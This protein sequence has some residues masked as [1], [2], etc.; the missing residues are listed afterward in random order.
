M[1]NTDDLFSILRDAAKVEGK[2]PPV[3]NWHPKNCG[4][5]DLTIKANGEWWHEGTPIG[6][7]KLYRLFSTVLRKDDNHYFLVT[8]VEKI[9]IEV[10]WQPFVIVD[11]D[12]IKKENVPVYIFTDSCENR[13][14]LTSKEQLKFSNFEEQELPIIKV[15]RN[16]YAS[17]SRSCYYRLVEEA[18]LKENTDKTQISIRS[19]N[20]DFIL[21]EFV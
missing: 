19:N 11:F 13:I 14:F 21:G 18:Q 15:R 20:L 6:R 16:L 4:E 7:K 8:P 12:V 1:T 9:A 2:L 3:E 10:E 17:F 5:M